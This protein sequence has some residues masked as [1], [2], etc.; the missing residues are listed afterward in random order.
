MTYMSYLTDLCDIVYDAMAYL[1][2]I[3]LV[4]ISIYIYIYINIFINIFINC[5]F[6][7]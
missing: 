2:H 4:Y 3:L 7:S 1:L 5:V 6:G